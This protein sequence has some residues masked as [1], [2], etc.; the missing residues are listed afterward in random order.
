MGAQS[1]TRTSRGRSKGGRVSGVEEEIAGDGSLEVGSEEGP[2]SR[3]GF[4]GRTFEEKEKEGE[5]RFVKERKVKEAQREEAG[6]CV[7]KGAEGA[8][9]R[10]G[11]R[12][13]RSSEEESTEE[14]QKVSRKERENVVK[15][16]EFFKERE[17]EQERQYR[18]CSRGKRRTV[19]RRKSSESSGRE[20]SRHLVLRSVKEYEGKPDDGGGRRY[21]FNR[22]SCSGREVLPPAAAAASSGPGWSRHA[23]RGFSAGFDLEGQGG[24]SSRF[25]SPTSQELRG[26]FE[27][28]PLVGVLEDGSAAAGELEHCPKV[29]SSTSSTGE[30][31]GESG[32]LSG[33]PGSRKKSRGEIWERQERERRKRKVGESPQR[34]SQ[35]RE[36]KGQREGEGS[37]K[38]RSREVGNKLRSEEFREVAL[39]EPDDLLVTEVES[40]RPESDGKVAFTGLAGDLTRLDGQVAEL[41]DPSHGGIVSSGEAKVG[42]RAVT[43]GSITG[44]MPPLTS[45]SSRN[46]EEKDLSAFCLEGL[47]LG[48]LG[49]RVLQLL[50]EVVPLRSK[51]TGGRTSRC[52]F[53]LPTSRKLLQDLFPSFSDGAISWMVGLCVGLNTVWGD[54]TFCEETPS[55]FQLELLGEV[56]VQVVR[57]DSLTGVL[58]PF[59]WSSFFKSRSVDY[60]GEEVK[61]ARYFSWANISPALPPEI[62]RV[63]LEEVC[64]LGSRYYVEHFD[65]F[66]RPRESWAP[67]STPK[68]MV[69]DE[70]WPQVCRG[71]LDAGLCGL[72]HRDEV[73]DTGEGPLLNGMFG[74]TK[75]EWHDGTEVFRLIMNLIPLNG[76]AMPLQGDVG[77]LPSWAGM[78]PF[79]LQPHENL[80]ISSEDV[81]CF[82]YTM[83]VPLAWHRYLAFNKV[84]PETILPDHLKGEEVYLASKVLP[85]GFLNSVSLAQHVHRNLVLASNQRDQQVNR[86]E[87]ELRK[88]KPFT[89]A[90]PCWR[91][92]LDNYDLLEKVQ[93]TEMVEVAGSEAVA[94]TA[95]RQEYQVWSVPRNMKKSVSRAPVAEVQGAEVNGIQG[96]AH[97]REV[98]L[99]RYVAATLHLC[100]S[101]AV[102]QR[103]MQVVCG[104]LVYISMFRRPLLGCLNRV[105]TFIEEFNTSTVRWLPLPVE[106]KLEMSRF[107]AMLPLAHLNFRLPMHP[108]VTCSDASTSGGGICGSQ[109]LTPFGVMASQG[110]LRGDLPAPNREFRVL[111]IGLFDGLG[112]L[113]V[114]LDLLG[115]E[116]LGHVSVEKSD[117]AS[118]VVEHHFP[119]T[120]HVKDVTLV[121]DFLVK[122]WSAQFSQAS[123]IILGAGPPCQGVSGL[124]CDRRGALRDARSV[125]FKHVSRI[126]ALIR[127]HFPWCP[128]HVLMES[129]SSMDEE[130]RDHMSQDFGDEPLLC[131]AGTMTWCS[132]PRYYWTTWDLPEGPGVDLF[133]D[134]A[135]KVQT[136]KLA[137]FQHLDDVCKEG[138][139]KVDIT[140]PFPTFTTSRPR[141]SPG[142]KPAGLQQCLHQ[143]LLRWSQDD[144]RFPPYQYAGRNCL[145]S[146]RGEVRLPSIEEKEVLMGFPLG[147]TASCSKKSSR[148]SQECLDARHTLVGNSWSV[149]VVAWLLG[150]LCHRLGLC[151]PHTPQ[152]VVDKL[153]PQNNAYLQSRLLRLP[154]RPLRGASTKDAETELAT[155]LGGLV[156]LKGEDLMITSS[157]SEQVRFHRL[158]ASVPSRLWKWRIIVGWRWRGNKEHIN[159]L[160]LRAILT[161]LQ[162][163]ICHQHHRHTRFLHLTDSLVCLH[164]LSR[165][166][167]SARKLRRTLSR[168]NALLL[169]SSCQAIWGYV[170]TDQNPADKPS[171]WGSRLRT[172]FRN[173]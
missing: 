13:P 90:D 102:T 45:G 35:G 3:K 32:G 173:G 109:G 166:R 121:D 117:A 92:Y 103:Q 170:H 52:A 48:K 131:D 108:M 98:K 140:R 53:P 81:R 9:W 139:M 94:V 118:R 95:L 101:A 85:M 80:L 168:I 128:V 120:I 54:E 57:L 144:Y 65:E 141:K 8:L 83:A 58:E 113:R 47:S 164:S 43:G 62:G 116:V 12:S 7:S 111:S 84:V 74:V 156:S 145:V 64:T 132:R 39:V 162:W 89:R 21:N 11:V 172:K 33:L 76:I 16:R 125:L 112:A 31:H 167:S 23:Q 10:H 97:P 153:L 72:L 79:F 37:G 55:P 86:P 129:V 36:R 152:M 42:D 5:E 49:G 149:P 4:G 60:R 91:V 148:K 1:R 69:R 114:A 119:G 50:L 133:Y 46:S 18:G 77:T 56:S 93:A 41:K 150:Q 110:V 127:V 107:I 29:R 154:L 135:K 138:W 2:R 169:V 82:F 24:G 15:Q 115:I 66:V 159:S 20:V 70:D 165:G 155:K 106:C 28:D 151:E 30:L 87:A 71:L 6:E 19:Q 137:A 100:G 40:G 44:Q 99:L 143:E 59:D 38:G 67:L 63:K 134:A 104:G 73:F 171:R 105:W 157:T 75:D 34:R 160:E 17:R 22:A 136:L 88:D 14:S 123:L 68:V 163:R 126:K 130:D 124:N 158:R 61:V 122:Q 26:H 147:Y 27:R 51:P 142:R 25:V 146:K 96:V 161:T 78:N